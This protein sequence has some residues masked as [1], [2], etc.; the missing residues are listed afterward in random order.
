MNL[1]FQNKQ[2]A[3]LFPVFLILILLIHAFTTALAGPEVSSPSNH[4]GH[5]KQSILMAVDANANS[6]WC[7]HHEGQSVQWQLELPV[8][9]AAK[10][11]S[12][13]SANDVPSRDPD[14]WVLEGSPEGKNWTKLDSRKN[15][16]EWE[17]RH[18]T[19]HFAISSPAAWKYFRFTFQFDDPTHYQ[20]SEIA[21]D[22]VSMKGAKIVVSRA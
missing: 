7:G 8:A 12:L 14:H 1:E 15:Q 9:I 21:F 11:Y 19:R 17:K 18:H 4:V 13:T 10:G 2:W 3:H 6:K 20:L 22:G 16:P 5:G